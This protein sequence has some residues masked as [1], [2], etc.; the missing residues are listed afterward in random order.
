MEYQDICKLNSVTI[1]LLF[2]VFT[3]LVLFLLGCSTS[4]QLMHIH[5]AKVHVLPWMR[6]RLQ[7]CSSPHMLAFQRGIH[8]S[9]GFLITLIHFDLRLLAKLCVLSP[10]FAE[11][12]GQSF[13]PRSYVAHMLLGC[14]L[15]PLLEITSS[16]VTEI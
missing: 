8:A 12:M 16:A 5:L 15:W 4:H 11:Q 2:L 10:Q 14:K 3:V 7:K 6:S 9:L 1:N 13:S